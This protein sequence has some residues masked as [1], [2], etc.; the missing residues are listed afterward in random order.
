MIASGT[1]VLADEKT[2][3]LEE[4][5]YMIMPR[6]GQNL[7]TYFKSCDSKMSKSSAYQLGIQII[8]MLE[9]IHSAGYVYNDLKLDNI[10]VDFNQDLSNKDL[11]GNVFASVPLHLVDFGFATK[12]VQTVFDEQAG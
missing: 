8:T 5:S 4:H 7:E 11:N 12:F 2:K 9:Q 10:M 1:V 3:I 6:L